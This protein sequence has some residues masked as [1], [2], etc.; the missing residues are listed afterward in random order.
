MIDGCKK[1]KYDQRLKKLYLTTIEDRFKRLDML[2]T[3]KILSDRTN[4]YPKDFLKLSDREGRKNSKKLYKK[5]INKE[6]RRNG[7]TFRIIDQ[8]NELPDRV[9]MAENVNMFK[10]E[11]DHLMREVGRQT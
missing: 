10:S 6:L 3:F 5:R 2:Q 1:L 7:F 8:W 11:Y 9:V 4:I